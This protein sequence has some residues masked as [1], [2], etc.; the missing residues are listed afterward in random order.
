MLDLSAA[1]DTVDHD[2]LI[3]RYSSRSESRDWLFPGSSPFYVT[4]R[5]Q[6]ASTGVQSTRSPLTCGV[7]QG[8]VLGAVL[9]LVY[10]ADVTAIGRRHGTQ[11]SAVT[12]EDEFSR[13]L[14]WSLENKLTVNSSKTKKII[15]HRCR[16]TRHDIPL[17]I[18]WH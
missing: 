2:I 5:S 10:C 3:G 14:N 8:S 16:L 18:T 7:P 17:S 13:L 15:F 4:G 12:L 6:S 1:F 11:Y 9:F